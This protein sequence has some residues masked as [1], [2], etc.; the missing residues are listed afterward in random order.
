M[1][2]DDFKRLVATG[3]TTDQIAIVMEMMDRD[4]RAYAEAEEAR[5][6]KGRDRVAKWR[7]EHG[8]NVTVTEQNVTVRL[9][10]GGA[11]VE[12][13][14]LTSEIEP[15][16]EEKKERRAVALWLEFEEFWAAY[17]NKVGKPKARASLQ[18]ALQN[19]SIEVIMSGLRRYIAAKPADRAWLNPATFLNQERWDDQPAVVVPMSRGS[20]AGKVTPYDVGRRL[21]DEM[22][23]ANA[24]TTAE[25]GGHQ[26]AP[27][28]LSSG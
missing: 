27:R 28:M 9:A 18:A 13:K 24:R 16:K 17:P 2:P 25:I 7:L 22:E 4:A 12:D 11:R 19:A 20:P 8:R 14:T 1:S 10:G 15:Q 23:T 21:L 5:K 3:M 26:S 6:A